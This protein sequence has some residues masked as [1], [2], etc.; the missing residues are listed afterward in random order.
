MQSQIDAV[1]AARGQ[2]TWCD[3]EKTEP[4]ADDY[5]VVYEGDDCAETG[6]YVACLDCEEREARRLL[7]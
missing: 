6:L 1:P 2:A 7:E 4:D 5:D 3:N